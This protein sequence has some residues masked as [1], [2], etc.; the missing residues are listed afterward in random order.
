MDVIELGDIAKD[1]I[2]GFKGVVV[3]RT[4]WLHGCDRLTLAP[5]ETHEGKVLD[6][7]SFDI[8]QCELVKKAKTKAEPKSNGGP[9]PVPKQTGSY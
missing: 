6:M 2:S 3:A 7:Q 9:R 8:G 5:Q 1:E 4:Q